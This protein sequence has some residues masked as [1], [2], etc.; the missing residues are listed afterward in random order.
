MTLRSAHLVAVTP[1]RCGLYETTR[2]IVANLRRAGVDSRLYDVTGFGPDHPVFKSAEVAPHHDR[3]VPIEHDLSWALEADVLVSHSGHEGTP[4]D[5]TQQP[6][7]HVAH[8]RPL[9]TYVGEVR[10]EL[11]VYSY[12]NRA[13]QNPRI[14][15]VVTF[16]PQHV[17]YHEVMF[18]H[19]PVYHVQSTVDL[20]LW[21][22]SA[23]EEPHDWNRAG[24]GGGGWFNAV[25]TDGWRDDVDPFNALNAWALWAR[26]HP[27]AKVH[28][29]GKPD[30]APGTD[31]I[32]SQMLKDGTVG[33]FRKW[34]PQSYLACVYRAAD[35]LITPH[36]IDTRAVREA[37]ACGCPVVRV[38]NDLAFEPPTTSREEV[39][40]L[41]ER[42]FNPA[43]SAAQFKV[44]LEKAIA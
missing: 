19:T 4:F 14:K 5:H 40:R 32:L 36:E 12:H 11:P 7:V 39:R 31:A 9:S 3:G 8:G 38:G 21:R 34:M 42:L 1:G 33:E 23:D 30:P 15:S 18:P 10:G 43:R 26:R 2:D 17:R 24:G 25:I 35:C 41:A 6:I 27:G 13:S 22:P 20:H 16:W 44:I 29:Y 28:L 37:M